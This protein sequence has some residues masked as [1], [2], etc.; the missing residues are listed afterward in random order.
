MEPKS[1]RP[2]KIFRSSMRFVWRNIPMLTVILVIALVIFPLT[3][4]IAAQKEDLA[5][6]QSHQMK[7]AKAATNVI[8][9][10]VLPDMVMEKIS[11]P[12][13]AKPW[14]FLTVAAEVKGKIVDKKIDQGIRV[15]KGDILAVIDKQEYQNNFDSAKASFETAMITEKRFKALSEKQFVT[16][17][18][19]DDAVSGVKTLKAAMDTAELNLNR[20]TIRSPMEGVVDRVFIENGNFLSVGD[21]VATILQIDRLKIE[22]GIPESDVAAVRKLSTFDMTID[23]LDGKSYTG[24]YHYLFKTTDSMARLYNLEIAV[25]N[26]DFQILPGMFARVTIIKKQDPQGLAVPIYALVIVN[27]QTGVFVENQNVVQFRPVTTGFLDGWKTQ[28][29]QG[30]LPGEKVVVV[31][32]KIIEDGE[33]VHVTRTIRRMEELTQ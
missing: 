20:C 4:K 10:E 32:H 16:Q 18:Q 13:V 2:K 12:G 24:E 1:T 6:E 27:K 26:P 3:K 28:I 5:Y 33:T 14:I 11:L 19:L 15:K 25:N 9:M 29:P 31:G 22:V 17:S 7:K 23:A 21:P 30:L 8:T